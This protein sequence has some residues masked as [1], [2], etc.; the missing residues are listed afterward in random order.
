MSLILDA[1]NRSTDSSDVIPTLSTQHPV[2]SVRNG[3]RQYFLWVVLSVALALIAW[4]LWS[5]LSGEPAPPDTGSPVAELTQNIGSAATSITTELK[6]RAE[7]REKGS[8]PPAV[9]S[10]APELT[11]QEVAAVADASATS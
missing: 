7:A 3:G 6:A 2:E 1:L 9:P 4:L 8:Q 5:R 10:S 11:Q